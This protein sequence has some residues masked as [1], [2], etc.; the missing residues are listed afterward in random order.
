MPSAKKVSHAPPGG[1]KLPP[2]HPGRTIGE[3]LK[4]REMT[5]HALSLKIRVPANRITEIVNG[6]RGVSAETAARQLLDDA[7][8]RGT[9]DNVTVVVIHH[10]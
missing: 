1:F 3:E 2:V 10:L 5:A 6:K 9:T 4:A 8:A 7:L